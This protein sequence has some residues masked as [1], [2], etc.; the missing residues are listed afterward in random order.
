MNLIALALVGLLA[1]D[2]PRESRSAQDLLKEASAQA[3]E[4]K[5]NV[6]LTFGG[7]G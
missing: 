1:Q 3:Q 6:F 2:A 4:S 5:K 7:P